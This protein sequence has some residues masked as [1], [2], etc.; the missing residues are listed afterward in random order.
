MALAKT[1]LVDWKINA[2]DRGVQLAHSKH[3]TSDMCN[4][5]KNTKIDLVSMICVMG[6]FQARDICVA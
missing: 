4:D 3:E 1:G 6:P 5:Y 2:N